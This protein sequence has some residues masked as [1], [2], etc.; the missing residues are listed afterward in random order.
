ML[1]LSLTL[2]IA[3]NAPQTFVVDPP[4]RI[5]VYMTLAD[6]FRA[7][8]GQLLD[9][10]SASIT[11]H[12][13]FELE[14]RPA[15]EL[16]DCEESL[17]CIVGV[18]E[19]SRPPVH[20]VVLV[21]VAR[22][23]G[24]GLLSILLVDVEHALAKKRAGTTGEA[25]DA[26]ILGN[27][28]MGSDEPVVVRDSNAIARYFEDAMRRFRPRLEQQK[29]TFGAIELELP[30]DDIEI[31]IDGRVLGVAKR[32]TVRLDRTRAGGRQLE[33]RLGDNKPF[34]TDAVVVVNETTS[35]AVETGD[36]R[37]KP[38]MLWAYVGVAGAGALALIVGG[39]QAATY[40]GE[41]CLIFTM[42]GEAPCE[43]GY[44]APGDWGGPSRATI[45][46]NDPTPTSQPFG[47]VPIG[48]GLLSAG[49]GAVL[50]DLLVDD[51]LWWLSIVTGVAA[52]ALGYG[53]MLAVE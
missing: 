31:A 47:F 12:S 51:E 25:L 11:R 34:R 4:G 20:W 17:S 18:L 33:L 2:V 26:A 19:S 7:D 24:G 29:P 6:T 38:Q 32:G 44:L 49:V 48:V 50:T 45:M 28:L 41:E 36:L 23:D 43:S 37:A 3:A 5:A 21:S 53:V 42:G 22:V 35:V 16:A 13:P 52:G 27:V 9:D 15:A 40:Q 14:R 46:L 1:S 8:E 39:I 30:T 10:T